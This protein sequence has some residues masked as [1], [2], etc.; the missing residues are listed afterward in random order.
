MRSEGTSMEITNIT[1]LLT[2]P[3]AGIY[4]DGTVIVLLILMLAVSLRLYLS[5]RKNAYISFTL[6]LVVLI[7]QHAVPVSME[8]G[9]LPD[10]LVMQYFYQLLQVTAFILIHMGVYQLYNRT[11]RKDYWMMTGFLAAAGILFAAGYPSDEIEETSRQEQLLLFVG[12]DVYLLFL[13]FAAFFLIPP[14]I[15]QTGKFRFSLAVYF[16]F[17]VCHLI[18]R[19][20]P[21]DYTVF[22]AALENVLP[23]AYYGILFLFLFERVVEIMQAVYHSSITDGLT[24]VYNRKYLIRRIHQYAAHRIKISLIFVDID[25]FKKLNDTQGHQTGDEMLRKVA[26][27]LRE[28]A[29]DIGMAGRYGGEELVLLV[30]DLRVKVKELAEK[31]RKRV[32]E[33]TIVTVSV[34][35]ATLRGNMSGETLIKHADAAMYHSKTTGKNK[36]TGYH[37]L[38]KIK[39]QPE[40]LQG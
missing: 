15:G 10:S 39:A 23:L 32:H 18:N 7:F 13:I 8:L 35:Y 12:L 2:G 37:E 25:N 17:H 22:Y 30:T 24:G 26:A 34:G 20:V 19:Y 16:L 33:E 40:S 28:E 31:I 36:V 27:I 14:Y 5:R 3:L 11:R 21:N 1:D 38:R 29:E 9:A 6:S 4:S